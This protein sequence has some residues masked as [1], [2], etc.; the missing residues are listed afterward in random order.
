MTVENTDWLLVQRVQQGDSRGFDLLVL[1]YQN[2]L[3]TVVSRYIK[4]QDEIKDVV[5]EAFIRAY[6]A[7]DS[8]RGDRLFYTWLYRIGINTAKNYLYSRS[9]KPPARDVDVGMPN[10]MSMPNC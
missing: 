7:I 10:F 1:K 5:Q 6:R 9:R 2:K 8:F 4:D 3:A